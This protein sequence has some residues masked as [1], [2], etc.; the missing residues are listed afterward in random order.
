MT[1]TSP[2]PAAVTLFRELIAEKLLSNDLTPRPD[3]TAAVVEVDDEVLP[4]PHAPTTIAITPAHPVTTRRLSLRTCTSAC[5]LL[6]SSSAR[7]RTH[8][9]SCCLLPGNPGRE[10]AGNRSTQWAFG[11]GRRPEHEGP[12]P[13]PAL[14]RARVLVKSSSHAREGGAARPPLAIG[15]LLTTGSGRT[16]KH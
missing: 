2:L 9:P 4:P 1:P 15:R 12:D 16:H 6:M 5:T 8:S 10:R 3:G 7:E 13:G 14:L 11:P